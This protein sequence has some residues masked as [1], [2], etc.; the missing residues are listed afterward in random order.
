MYSTSLGPGSGS[1]FLQSSVAYDFLTRSKSHW[2]RRYGHQPWLYVPRHYRTL[3]R[4][5]L[6]RVRPVAE[7]TKG[8]QQQPLTKAIQYPYM[9]MMSDGREFHWFEVVGT[10]FGALHVPYMRSTGT[11]CN[12]SKQYRAPFKRHVAHA[13]ALF[14]LPTE[15]RGLLAGRRKRMRKKIGYVAL[16]GCKKRGQWL[17]TLY[18]LPWLQSKVRCMSNRTCLAGTASELPERIITRSLF[19]P[20]SR[21]RRNRCCSRSFASPEKRYNLPFCQTRF[22]CFFFGQPSYSVASSP[23]SISIPPVLA[24]LHSITALQTHSCPWFL[25]PSPAVVPHLSPLF[26]PFRATKMGEW[27]KDH[28][29]VLGEGNDDDDLFEF[30]DIPPPSSKNSRRCSYTPIDEDHLAALF[31]PSSPAPS[32]GFENCSTPSPPTSHLGNKGEDK[33][34]VAAILD[35]VSAAR[36]RV[37]EVSVG[38][39]LSSLEDDNDADENELEAFFAAASST[40][41]SST[42]A[43]SQGLDCPSPFALG[44]SVDGLTD[45]DVAISSCEPADP[46]PVLPR[47]PTPESSTSVP[48]S[49]DEELGEDALA[50]LFEAATPTLTPVASGN[51]DTPLLDSGAHED[52]TQTPTTATRETPAPAVPTLA[53][54]IEAVAALDDYEARKA[55]ISQ[56]IAAAKAAA[57]ANNNIN[58]NTPTPPTSTTTTARRAKKTKEKPKKPAVLLDKRGLPLDKKAR[59]AELRRRERERPRTAAETEATHATAH[60][61]ASSSWR[62]TPR[63][64]KRKAWMVEAEA[65]AGGGWL[66]EQGGAGVPPAAKPPTALSAAAANSPPVLPTAEEDERCAK[67]RATLQ[68]M[69][70]RGVE[71]VD[72][73]LDDSD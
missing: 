4:R 37:L 2:P 32:A 45:D 58:N 36:S 73:L 26:L 60:L 56:M 70:S 69:R 3:T 30:K 38:I 22:L 65:A 54:A 67:R 19:P 11:V 17:Q 64:D 28:S 62:A 51:L 8:M 10:T 9:G 5:T 25:P 34:D 48:E 23:S 61:F 49:S 35:A 29:S 41:A 66:E 50:A 24:S 6:T 71:I 27:V 44:P 13:V 59:R 42:A 14:Q 15:L 7:V 46:A 12:G 21:S 52:G 33:T 63:R 31:A 20:C 16:S 57:V 1:F 18:A 55:A 72:L 43:S 47:V 68:E 40:A 53:A 39:H